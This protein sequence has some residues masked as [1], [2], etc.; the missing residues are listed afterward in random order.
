MIIANRGSE[1]ELALLPQTDG[2]RHE[3]AIVNNNTN[4]IVACSN[5]AGSIN[6]FSSSTIQMADAKACLMWSAIAF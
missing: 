3:F 4:Q 2:R 5:Q 6:L 1:N